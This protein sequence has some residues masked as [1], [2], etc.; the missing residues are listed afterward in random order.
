[1]HFSFR[2]IDLLH[3]MQN[4]YIDTI[5]LPELFRGAYNELFFLVDNPADV[6][7]NPSGGK[8]GVGAP[9]EDDDVQLGPAAPCLRSG[10][11][12]RGIAADDDQFFFDHGS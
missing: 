11:H 7:G 3:L 4:S 8:G 12:P 10:A 5:L 6:I 1:M 9:L 2:R